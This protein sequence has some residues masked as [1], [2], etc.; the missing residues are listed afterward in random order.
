[1]LSPFPVSLPTRNTL[2]HPPS[3]CFYEGVPLLPPPCPPFPYTGTSI[4]PSQ[5]QRPLLPLIPDKAILCYICIW[6]HVYSFV[7]GLVPGNSGCVG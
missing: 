4:E 1:M 2:S 3:P 5:D 6:S 7:D